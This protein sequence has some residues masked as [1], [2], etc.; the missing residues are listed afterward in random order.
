MGDRTA[1]ET[2]AQVF[3][4][5]MT[6]RTLSQSELARRVGVDVRAVRRCLFD[7]KAAGMPLERD[8]DHPH[9]YWSVPKN[10]VPGG[11]VVPADDLLEIVR[12]LLRAPHTASRDRVLSR[13]I[14]R[15]GLGAA[16]LPVS[17]RVLSP[18]LDEREDA[19]LRAAED[20]LASERALRM[21]WRS[22][23]LGD[24]EDRTISVQRIVH[25]DP[26][27]LVAH[28]H[29]D[30]CLKWFRIDN[31]V[32]ARV[33]RDLAAYVVSDDAIERFLADTH[34][35]YHQRGP[36]VVHSFVVL[37][38]AHRWVGRQLGDVREST[39]VPGGVRFVV[40]TSSQLPLA[41]FLVSLGAS[42]RIETAALAAEV[43]RIAT[44]ALASLP[45]ADA[46]SSSDA[47]DA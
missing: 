24:L 3:L 30:G 9:V 47:P 29:R 43:R 20:A 22:T 8:E 5:L 32:E 34:F 28:C 39:P 2:L 37:D 10:W 21:R 16:A 7:M 23:R 45:T 25:G 1:T 18:E 46:T 31:V 40:E 17:E 13:V 11:S 4:T 41:R 36:R 19:M 44:D 14:A 42:V 38:P 12:N 26:P 15:I 35:G 33:D 6:D 27:K